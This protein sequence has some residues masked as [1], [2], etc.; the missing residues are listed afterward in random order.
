[1]NQPVKFRPLEAI[2]VTTC[3]LLLTLALLAVPWVVALLGA[4]VGVH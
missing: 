2:V 1:M 4:A 3:A